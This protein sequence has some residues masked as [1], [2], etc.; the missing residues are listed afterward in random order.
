MT[1]Y[2][3]F[4]ARSLEDPEGFW[5]EQARL[6]DW[7]TPFS[8]VLDAPKLPFRA[9]FVGGQTNLAHNALDR[10]LATRGSQ[11]ALVWI[12]T[13]TNEERRFTYAELHAEVQRFAAALAEQGVGK[14]DRVL[15]YMPM[16]PEAVFAMLATVRLGAIH[17]VV[18]GGFAAASLAARIDDARPKVM[19]TGD[20][21]MR[22]GKLIALKPLVDESIR[23]AKF[24]PA[25]VIVANRGLDPAFT[26]VAGRDLDWVE[27]REKHRD[28]KVPVTW[29]ES[30]EP[31]YILYTSGTT[32]KPKGVLRDTGGYAVALASS[33]KHIFCA[34]PGTAYFCTSDIGWVVGHSYIVY[35]P[36]I[37]GSTTIMYEGVPVRPDAAIWWKIVQDWK[38][39][40]MFSSPTA[41]RVLKKQDPKFM[42]AHDTSSLRYLFLAG[43][44]LDE[45]TARWVSDNLGGT[46]IVDN[47]W[48]TESGWPILTACPGVEDTPRKF[49]SPSFPAY[50]Y[51]VKIK[52]EETGRECGPDEKGVLC[53]VPPL[54][55]GGMT[56]IWGDDARYVQTYYTSFKDEM[57]YTTFDWATRDADGYYFVLGRTDDVINV[58]GHRLGTREIEEAVQAHPNIAEVAVVGV[59]DAVKGQVPV[60]FAVVKDVAKI[61][62]PELAAAHEKEIMATVDREIG[63]IARPSRVCFVTVLPK[64]RSGKL[65]RRS[66][67]ALCEGRDPG[68]LTTIEDPAALEQ[69]KT[70]LK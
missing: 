49:G 28:A 70:A 47:Y 56:T 5:A 32:G 55:P 17:S 41:I 16:V 45:P 15:I 54:P 26:R 53:I 25:R 64:T 61:A 57:V 34:K 31:S 20:A 29:L 37:N 44:P 23:L 12:S 22:M 18:F 13:E 59:A 3:E 35:G 6:I 69:I 39:S 10:H 68:D 19:V 43:E 30:N 7:H 1:S 62:T 11:L 63:A 8:K 52:H 50:G 46:A 40:S 66:I 2:R 21:G 58:A 36:L 42:R 38:V 9:W 60:A 24:P 33:M 4:H 27:L 65:L 51:R 67:Q 48:Q 14:G